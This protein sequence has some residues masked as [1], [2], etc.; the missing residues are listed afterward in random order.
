MQTIWQD[1]KRTAL[2]CPLECSTTVFIHM[3]PDTH[4][5]HIIATPHKAGLNNSSG[6]QLCVHSFS[7]HLV[8]RI[9]PARQHTHTHTRKCT[10]ANMCNG[11]LCLPR[12]DRQHVLSEIAVPTSSPDSERLG[13]ITPQLLTSIV[14]TPISQVPDPKSAVV[15]PK[16]LDCHTHAS[17]ARAA[18]W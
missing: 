14:Q 5:L 2:Q 3:L 10:G 7:F 18:L 1:M 11:E 6:Q 16:A 4:T 9:C 13:P 8:S 17:F 15:P 12:C